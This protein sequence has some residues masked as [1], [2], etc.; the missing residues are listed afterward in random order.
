MLRMM[1]LPALFLCWTVPAF[2]AACDLRAKASSAATTYEPFA[3]VDT[4]FD[5]TLAVSN[6]GDQPCVGRFFVAPANGLLR[7]TSGMTTL[8]YRIEA[9]RS[10]EVALPNAYGPFT[11]NVPA[12][13]SRT[14]SVRFTIP[15]KQV[16]PKGEFAGEL[17]IVGTDAEAKPIET[18]GPVAIRVQ[19]PARVE[20]GL[21][22]TAAA[23]GG[24]GMAAASLD[25]REP[26]PGQTERLYLN[27]WANGSVT[28]SIHSRNRGL[29][30]L[31]G[32]EGLA[33]IRYSLRFDGSPVPLAGAFAAPRTP[34]LDVAGG[35]YE[36][37]V[38]LDDLGNRYGGT[39]QDVLT[40]SVNEN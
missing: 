21:A 5:L 39:Y 30:R 19:F 37:A 40:I 18:G 25:F 15:A 33:P 34:P 9:Q 26:R 12:R 32:H 2:A 23:A 17:L 38:T 16:L 4:A 20:M 29:L 24:L 7:L 28:V 1:L 27:V 10:G 6:D 36:L 35:R 22:G 14:T 13:A 11:V 8:Y 31:V 3:P